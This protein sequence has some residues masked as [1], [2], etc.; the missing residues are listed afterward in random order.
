MKLWYILLYRLWKPIFALDNCL[1]GF[2]GL[3]AKPKPSFLGKERNDVKDPLQLPPS[4]ILW[5]WDKPLAM[6]WLPNV[7]S[8]SDFRTP[9]R[10]NIQLE[11]IM[12]RSIKKIQS[13]IILFISIMDH[14]REK[15]C[16][17]GLSSCF[18]LSDKEP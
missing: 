11:F 14:W 4:A 6:W 5:L 9:E 13:I 8:A 3:T 15:I 16:L 10:E 17:C 7:W 12:V 18:P 2:Y 1:E